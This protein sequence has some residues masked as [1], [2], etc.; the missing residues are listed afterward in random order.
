MN[1]EIEDNSEAVEYAESYISNLKAQY[2]SYGQ[3]FDEVLSEYYESEEQFKEII[4]NDYTKN[5]VAEKFIKNTE[6]KFI[7]ENI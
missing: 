4:T 3:N 7:T 1:K 6:N 5:L 2:E